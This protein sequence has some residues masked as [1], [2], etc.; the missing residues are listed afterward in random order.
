M[1]EN[2]ECIMSEVANKLSVILADTYALYLKTQNY[3]WHVKGTQFKSLHELFEMQYRELAEAIDLIAERLVILG[4]M[5]PATF[6]A[7]EQ[8]K[9]IND[10]DSHLS[11]KQ[12]VMDLA[13]DNTRLVRDM[14]DALKIVQKNHDEATVSMLADRISAHEKA[15]WMLSASHD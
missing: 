14:N 13:D 8:L 11:A 3:H 6:K 1:S 5:A 4:H 15:R 7:L 2:R 10:G 9:T 12:M